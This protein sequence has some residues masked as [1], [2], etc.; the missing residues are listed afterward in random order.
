MKFTVKTADIK[1]AGVSQIK[2]KG[3]LI[4]SGKEATTLILLEMINPC[5]DAEILPGRVADQSY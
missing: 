1:K 2:V 4:E 5:T 3:R